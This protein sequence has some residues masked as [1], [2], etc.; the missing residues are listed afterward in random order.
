VFAGVVACPCLQVSRHA[1][2]LMF[3]SRETASR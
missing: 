2:R 3:S 1:A